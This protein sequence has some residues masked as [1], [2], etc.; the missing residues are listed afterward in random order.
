GIMGDW[1]ERTRGAQVDVTL[2]LDRVPVLDGAR[3]TIDLGIFS[4]RKP[5]NVRLRRAIRDL[6]KP[7]AHPD[8]PLL[9]DPQTAGGLLASV[10][11][12]HAEACVAELNRAGYRQ[13]A[14]IGFVRPRGEELESIVIATA[15]D[16]GLDAMLGQAVAGPA[17]GRTN[18]APQTV[19]CSPAAHP[20]VGR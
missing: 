12:A 1:N 7:E 4:S 2:A 3:A 13:A 20:P 10:P 14:A 19:P 17:A 9:F 18:Q 11:A 15:A 5:K 6:D 8:Y 16:A